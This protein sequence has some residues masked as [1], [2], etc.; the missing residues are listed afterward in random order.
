MDNISITGLSIRLVAVPTYPTGITLT[1]FPDDTDPLDCD[2]N[3]IAGAAVGL[4]GDLIV[5]DKPGMIA[6]RIA[7]IPGSEDHKKL[8]RLYEVNRTSKDKVSAQNRIQA[9]VRYANGETVSL[10]EGYMLSGPPLTGGNAEGKAKTPVYGFAF[11]K[12]I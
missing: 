1:Q 9:V 12:R 4:N 6:M 10:A 11:E 8:N 7:V 3:E 2:I 5:W